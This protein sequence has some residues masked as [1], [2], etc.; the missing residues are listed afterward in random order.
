MHLRAPKDSTG[1]QSMPNCRFANSG[2]PIRFSPSTGEAAPYRRL[3]DA[4]EGRAKVNCLL[5]LAHDE[6]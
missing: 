2:Y 5:L 3:R 6:W 1:A 4:P